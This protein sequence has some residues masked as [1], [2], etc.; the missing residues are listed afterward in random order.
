MSVENLGLG[1]KGKII[2][3]MLGHQE[4]PTV[5]TILDPKAYLVRVKDYITNTIPEQICDILPGFEELLK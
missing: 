2:G 3:V 5:A 4:T 1:E